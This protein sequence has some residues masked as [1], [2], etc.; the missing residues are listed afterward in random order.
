MSGKSCVNV[1]VNKTLKKRKTVSRVSRGTVVHKQAQS[2]HWG[3]RIQALCIFYFMF[4]Y[5]QYIS[6]N[7]KL[8][9][10]I[11]KTTQL[12]GVVWAK[13]DIIS[14]AEPNRAAHYMMWHTWAVHFLTLC[15]FRGRGGCN[16][17]T[18]T[19]HHVSQHHL[20]TSS[21]KRVWKGKQTLD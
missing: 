19:V 17:Q 2:S 9:W 16:L 8:K 1:K 13:V 10:D 7:V 20:N 12:Y 6:L 5:K 14:P 21:V 3:H 18:L 11:C 15:S 4:K